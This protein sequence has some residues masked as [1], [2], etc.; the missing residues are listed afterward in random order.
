[1]QL[2]PSREQVV[3][4]HLLTD[5]MKKHQC[6]AFNM[7]PLPD[8]NIDSA[9]NIKAL[10]RLLTEKNIVSSR[11]YIFPEPKDDR[12]TNV[13]QY[14]LAT[15]QNTNTGAEN[16]VLFFAIKGAHLVA[17][18]IPSVSGMP[19]LPKS[20]VGGIPLASL[21]APVAH[22]LLRLPEAQQRLLA[23]MAPQQR[24]DTLK[25]WTMHLKQNQPSQGG[26][27]STSQTH[28]QATPGNGMAM[29]QSTPQE[30]MAAANGMPLQSRMVLP[31]GPVP[32]GFAGATPDQQQ[33]QR[34]QAQLQQM[35]QTMQAGGGMMN[36]GLQQGMQ[37]MAATRGLG[38]QGMHQR[39][40]SGGMS[41]G[42]A[43]LPPDVLQS[44]MQRKPTQDG[45]NAGMR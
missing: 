6:I 42:M 37:Q 12:L 43:G 15:W 27:A 35:Q 1:M 5:W 11:C 9:E 17:V 33:Q 41:G 38:P 2:T 7:T 31:S 23:A 29:P 18:F 21:P 36:F 30:M 40:P 4:I 8:S 19:E 14:A 13:E 26:Q 3:P 28:I 32:M 16:R 24:I 10:I 34:Q 25:K 39:N 20:S 44:F 45:A 22:V